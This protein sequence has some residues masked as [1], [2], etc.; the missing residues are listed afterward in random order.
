M[1]R[2]SGRRGGGRAYRPRDRQERRR[3]VSL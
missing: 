1:Q 3:R 2:Q